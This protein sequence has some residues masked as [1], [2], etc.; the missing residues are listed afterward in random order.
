MVCHLSKLARE[1]G[2]GGWRKMAESERKPPK[3][4]VTLIQTH[5]PLHQPCRAKAERSYKSAFMLWRAMRL[6][7]R[8]VLAA[9]ICAGW[10]A[11]ASASNHSAAQIN[12]FALTA[13]C[14]EAQQK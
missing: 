6:C 14:A 8:T 4:Q 1:N 12:K 13:Y 5:G 10:T 9:F 11:A 7:L 3:W 2:S